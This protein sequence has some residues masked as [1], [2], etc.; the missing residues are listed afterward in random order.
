MMPAM[1]RAPV[2]A[3]RAGVG[4]MMISI[5]SE[6]QPTGQLGGDFRLEGDNVF[7][8]ESDDVGG[9]GRHERGEVHADDELGRRIGG[10][11]IEEGGICGAAAEGGEV[12]ALA[13]GDLG[14]ENAV[15]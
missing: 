11:G 13:A 15:E 14:I 7:L 4:W 2:A 6:S 3:A 10:M 12:V 9:V 1:I 5:R 8:D